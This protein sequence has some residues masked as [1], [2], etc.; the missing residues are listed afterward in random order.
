MLNSIQTTG[1]YCISYSFWDIFLK[2]IYNLS[3]ANAHKC[4]YKTYNYL[5]IAIIC[6]SKLLWQ[7][8]RSH[9]AWK[10]L[11]E[12]KEPTKKT[13]LYRYY[14]RMS[15]FLSL[16]GKCWVLTYN[17]YSL[18]KAVN[19]LPIQNSGFQILSACRYL[20][21]E[22]VTHIVYIGS[23]SHESFKHFS[24]IDFSLGLL[25]VSWAVKHAHSLAN[26]CSKRRW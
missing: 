25:H 8:F 13:L 12:M 11:H 9:I 19:V 20:D 14:I 23:P 1:I 4:G 26:R 17:I 24:V 10:D 7:L 3:L 2:Y 6:R 15:M 5:F 18:I 16:S 22:I 21:S